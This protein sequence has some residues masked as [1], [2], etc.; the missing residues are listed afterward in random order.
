MDFRMDPS[1]GLDDRLQRLEKAIG[2]WRPLA[3]FTL[4]LVLLLAAA[5]PFAG[6]LFSGTLSGKVKRLVVVDA[7]GRER[8]VL[9]GATVELFNAEGDPRLRLTTG[10][11]E[12]HLSVV[13]VGGHDRLQLGLDEH[14]AIRQVLRDKTERE[15]ITL[16][17]DDAGRASGEYRDVL[18]RLRIEHVTYDRGDA[19]SIW[20]DGRERQRIAALIEPEG[21]AKFLLSD[22]KGAAR[23]RDMTTPS[24]DA[25]RAVYDAKKVLRAQTLSFAS[26]N[27]QQ[28]LHGQDEEVR[29]GMHAA[30]SGPTIF[31][32]RDTSDRERVLINIDSRGSA[33]MVLIDAA[34]VPRL[35]MSADEVSLW[36]LNDAKG[37][38]RV[39]ARS[40]AEESGLNL[41]DV[42]GT[43]RFSGA[44]YDNPEQ[45]V[46]L[47]LM[48]P[49][50]RPRIVEA[51][52]QTGG[53][54]I[55]VL[56]TQVV[57]RVVLGTDPDGSAVVGVNDGGGRRRAEQLVNGA[58]E[59]TV[60]VMDSDEVERAS[61]Y[62]IPRGTAGMLIADAA[63][64]IR[65]NAVV[66][67][68]MNARMGLQTSDG[69][70]RLTLGTD[71]NGESYVQHFDSTGRERMVEGSFSDVVGSYYV[72][73]NNELRV[74]FET[75]AYG[76]ALTAEYPAGTFGPGEGP[77]AVGGDPDP[78]PLTPEG[79]PAPAP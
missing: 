9:D 42:D 17:V 58:D 13:G 55:R 62:A 66:D 38:T 19:A 77:E 69:M 59:S 64:T 3:L 47:V 72:D 20:R 14:N 70:T 25:E 63:A 78:S 56:D 61:F 68:Q 27:I 45:L 5:V 29:I 71:A 18:G 37:R 24:D 8:I 12:G 79:V 33:G 26:G 48:D 31:A 36:G 22:T 21:A 54:G 34:S 76:S 44:T 40:A 46:S 51:V 65:L 52:D 53:A 74:Q 35:V 6:L 60:R 41:F 23:I 75:D 73:T 39:A 2:R 57:N 32:M 30:D 15:R 28:T 1:S 7:E 4:V 49:E 16:S 67:P 50:G 11:R 43:M 10:K